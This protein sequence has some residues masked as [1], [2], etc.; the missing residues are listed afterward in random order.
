MNGLWATPEARAHGLDGLKLAL[1]LAYGKKTT[2]HKIQRH[3]PVTLSYTAQATNKQRIAP[4]TPYKGV[5]AEIFQRPLVRATPRMV[6]VDVGTQFDAF[7][8]VAAPEPPEPQA[9]PTAT[10]L[11]SAIAS[12]LAALSARLS[13]RQAR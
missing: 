2:S 1:G 11:P 9:P 5:V 8:S 4:A 12:A 10:H 3:A 7:T 6:M 13:V